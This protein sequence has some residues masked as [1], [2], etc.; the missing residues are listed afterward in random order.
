MQFNIHAVK[1]ALPA[2]LINKIV[3]S[4]IVDDAG[5][6]CYLDAWKARLNANEHVAF[7]L[8]LASTL[9]K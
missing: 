9:H 3:K 1:S 7:E 5:N 2:K 6:F 4:G 8:A